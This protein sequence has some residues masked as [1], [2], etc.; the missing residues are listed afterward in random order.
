MCLLLEKRE[1]GRPGVSS[2]LAPGCL[3][4]GAGRAGALAGLPGHLGC[5]PPV[6]S[7]EGHLG[8]GPPAFPPTPIRVSWAVSHLCPR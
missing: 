5:A 1:K 3:M 8:Y 4:R 2:A 6:S 7:D